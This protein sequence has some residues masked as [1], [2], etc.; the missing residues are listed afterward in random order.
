[1][2]GFFIEKGVEMKEILKILN[3]EKIVKI[4]FSDSLCEI[5]KIIVR[6]ILLKEKYVY[7]VEYF[8]DNKAYHKNLNKDEMIEY[9]TKNIFKFKQLLIRTMQLEYIFSLK[10][11]KYTI[12]KRS[13]ENNK[14]ILSHNK[15][16]K[17]FL[18]EGEDIDFLKELDIMS[19]NNMVYKKSI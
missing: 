16:K 13:I 17:Y 5:N 4:V 8:M 11:S 12:R 9:L 1:M 18:N 6:E 3:E 15:S 19:S 2:Y 10:K 14:K 7:Q